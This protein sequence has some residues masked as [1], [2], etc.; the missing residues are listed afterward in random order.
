[1]VQ[2]Q[3]NISHLQ[4]SETALFEL[5][6]ED[7]K[8]FYTRHKYRYFQREILKAYQVFWVQEVHV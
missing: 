4:T 3:L 7:L 6:V 5:C 2:K 8:L 1:M